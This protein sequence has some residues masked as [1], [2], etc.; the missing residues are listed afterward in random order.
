[1]P[2]IDGWNQQVQG[3]R[4]TFTPHSQNDF[5][6]EV[7]PP[8]Q[9]V[10]ELAGWL[11]KT[12][13]Q[14]VQ[15]AGYNIPATANT[16]RRNFQAINIW[17]SYAK[18]KWG[19]AKN[20][21]LLAYRRADNSVRYAKIIYPGSPKNTYLNNAVDHFAAL[22]RK[23][24]VELT[25][26]KAG[27][28]GGNKQKETTT[29]TSK[30][31]K[32]PTTAPGQGV[33]PAEIRGIVINAETGIGVGGM[34]IIEYR[35]YLLL[36]NGSIYRYPIVA[37]YDLDVAA[38]KIAE[39]NKWGAWK[40]EGKTLV[41]TLPEKGVMKTKRWTGKWFWAKAPVANEKIKG[42]YMTIGG[43]GNTAL[44]GNTMIVY[45]GNINFNDKGQFVMKKTAGGS[46]SDFD[47]STTTYSNSNAAGTYKLNGYSIE[48]KYNNGQVVRK[49][50]YFYPD[51]RTTFG[52]GDDAYVPD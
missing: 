13:K 47:V 35:P 51:S 33:K 49:L 45:S 5:L 32:T 43:G 40:L 18:N 20:F 16:Q 26:D 12:A 27:A 28:G 17:G 8:E 21:F 9:H 38:S 42:A 36:Q 50:F 44:G 24:G 14:T 3:A 10:G 31:Q 22:A 15:E 46:N 2:P 39:P 1:M 37:P 11:D 6:Y 34:V 29:V 19:Q 4:Y 41:V 25:P 52:I 7:M 30:K 23:E 48:M